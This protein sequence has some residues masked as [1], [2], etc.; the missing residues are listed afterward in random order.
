MNAKYCPC[1]AVK[2]FFVTAARLYATAPESTSQQAS[3]SPTGVVLG[4]EGS[5]DRRFVRDQKLPKLTDC[6][7]RDMG[8]SYPDHSWIKILIRIGV[9][10]VSLVIPTIMTPMV[11]ATDR[12]QEISVHAG[13]MS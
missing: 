12:L 4:L 11:A 10:T 7:A 1:F 2:V 3:P 5:D 9:M 6:A 13:N 8:W